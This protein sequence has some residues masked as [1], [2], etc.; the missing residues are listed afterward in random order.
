[1]GEMSEADALMD[2]SRAIG[3][4]A[5]MDAI[6]PLLPMAY[7]LACGLLRDHYE[8]EDVLQEATLKAWKHR[9]S[10]RAGSQIRPW[11]L[12]IVANQCRQTIRARWWSVIRRPDLSSIAREEGRYQ[13]DEVESLKQ[14]LLQ[15]R[16]PDRFV[17]VLRYYLDLSFEDV[18]ATLHISSQAARVRTHRALARLRPIVDISGELNDE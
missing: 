4:D 15:L 12:A 7:R 9:R 17:L 2:D 10:L 16:G 14:A 3:P 11:F 1:M 8:A 13:F 5:F 6:D 18:A